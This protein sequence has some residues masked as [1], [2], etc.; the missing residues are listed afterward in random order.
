M[1]KF[2]VP[3]GLAGLMNLLI[4]WS[5]REPNLDNFIKEQTLQKCPHPFS[6][7]FVNEI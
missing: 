5:W 2:S 4:C 3:L 1:M 6:D 7:K